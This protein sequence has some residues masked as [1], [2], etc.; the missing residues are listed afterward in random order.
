[1]AL[2]ADDDSQGPYGNFAV[3]DSSQNNLVQPR[4]NDKVGVCDMKASSNQ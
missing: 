1:M 2:S 3:D 4:C